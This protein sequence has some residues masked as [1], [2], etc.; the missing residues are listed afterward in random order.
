MYTISYVKQ[1]QKYL[2]RFSMG[3]IKVFLGAF[4]NSTNAQNLNCLALS[5]YLDNEKFDIYTLTV[6]SGNLKTKEVPGVK[7][8]NCFYPFR[9]SKYIGFLWGIIQCDV[10]YLPKGKICK[11]N[12]FWIKLLGK[13]SFRTVEGIY[14]EEMLGQILDS[15]VTYK[16]FKN[17]FLRYDKVYSITRY[18]KEYNEKH[19]GIKTEEKILYL[20]TDTDTFLNEKKRIDSLKNIIFIGRIKRRKGV[21]DY[22]E[23]AKSFPDLNFYMAG[24]GEDLKEVEAFIEKH[25]LKNVTY[26]GTL[27]HPK[28]AKTLENIDL[29][30][31]PSRSE[32]FPK[33]TLETAAAGVPSVVY[34]DYGADE[35]IES[36][37]DGFIVKDVDETKNL[38]S[39]LAKNPDRLAKISKNAIEMAKRFDWKVVIK[40]WEKVIEEL[41][42]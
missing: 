9:I 19:H 42:A 20:G 32:G 28:L 4:I 40:E 38:L 37:V 34:P 14:G 30:I 10:A 15:G 24:N 13:K 12:K 11:W 21:F 3:K 25:N 41:Y 31:F 1:L 36:G 23:L 8:F 18:L 7:V 33:V 27:T 16:E 29:H 35:W 5:K 39:D 22:L 17:S 26:L 6:Y 2:E